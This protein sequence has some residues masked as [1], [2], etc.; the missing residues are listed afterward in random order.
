[1]WK[2][3]D[4]GGGGKN[5]CEWLLKCSLYICKSDAQCDIAARAWAGHVLNRG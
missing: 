4:E 2:R 3:R 5:E 1:M